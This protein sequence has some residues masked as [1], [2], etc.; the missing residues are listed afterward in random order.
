MSTFTQSKPIVQVTHVSKSYRFR[1]VLTDISFTLEAGRRVALVG[2]SGCGKTTLL[3]CLGGIDR[4]DQGSIAING[5][6]LESLSSQELTLM[7]RSSIGTIFQF[8]HLLPT[9]SVFEN[10]EF[11]LQLLG[12]EAAEREKRVIELLD[13]VG[14]LHR[15]ASLPLELSG[16]EMQRVAIAR[17][18]IHRPCIV[19]ADEPTGNLDS[20]NGANVL[21]LLA[22]LSDEYQITMLMVTHSHEATHICHDVVEMQDGRIINE[23]KERPPQGVSNA[24]GAVE[25]PQKLNQ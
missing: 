24:P 15:K 18:L 17:A 14:L 9:L 6:K 1:P 23:K 25:F 19:L 21:E 22:Q 4:S 12:I 13:R 3:N 16:G 8:F 7:R 10:V 5:R 20:V 11:P 2:P